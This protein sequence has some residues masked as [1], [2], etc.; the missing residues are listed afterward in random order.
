M[1]SGI[2]WN[3]FCHAQFRNKNIT[4]MKK[5]CLIILVVLVGFSEAA[6]AQKNMPYYSEINVDSLIAV[7]ENLVLLP[8]V[9]VYSNKRKAARANKKYDKLVYNFK[10]V[11]PYVIEV[12]AIYRQIEDSLARMDS[13]RQRRK[14]MDMREDQIMAHYKP[15]M[16][17][18]TLQQAI[19]FVKLL[20]R[21]CGSTAYE[22]IKTLKGGFFAGSCQ[23]FA[24]MFGNNL[25]KSYDSE[26]SDK[27]LEFLVL[28]Y[29]AGKLT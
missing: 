27:T 23:V 22:I 16:T 8:E 19:I 1:L 5:F 15:I 29:R 25:K 17:R 10:K 24:C 12:S 2:F 4:D 7:T 14:Y 3:G 6:F 18:F 9:K 11:Y 20:D 28:Q 21:E 13:D 26:V